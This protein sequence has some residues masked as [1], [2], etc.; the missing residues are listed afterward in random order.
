MQLPWIPATSQDVIFYRHTLQRLLGCM[1]VTLSWLTITFG[2]NF[3]NVQS[4]NADLFW[5]NALFLIFFN[6]SNEGWNS[7]WEYFY[8][9]I[10][11]ICSLRST[12][13]WITCGD[14][15]KHIAIS[16]IQHPLFNK[17]FTRILHAYSDYA[18][19]IHFCN[20]NIM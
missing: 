7:Q 20:V 13:M 4:Y 11:D 3:C 16:V 18:I 6:R 15:T 10:L 19:V 1:Y 12:K 5:T 9:N 14:R 8:K 2:G 17:T